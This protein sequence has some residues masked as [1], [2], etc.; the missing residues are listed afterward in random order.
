MAGMTL[1]L[2]LWRLMILRLVFGKDTGKNFLGLPR[3][4]TII[5]AICAIPWLL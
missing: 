5:V 2:H 1:L 3:Q 4:I